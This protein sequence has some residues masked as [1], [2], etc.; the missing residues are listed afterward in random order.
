LF[1]Y[2]CEEVSFGRFPFWN[3]YENLGQPFAGSPT[4]L[5]FYPITILAV[6]ATTLSVDRDYA[7]SFCVGFHVLV[8]V[9]TCY[10]FIHINRLTRA[11]AV[12]GGL[13]YAFSGAVLFQWNNL[14]F[15]IGAAW[16]PEALRQVKIILDGNHYLVG[17]KVMDSYFACTD[18]SYKKRS[19]I[20]LNIIALA[21]VLSMLI[22]GGDPQ[23]AYNVLLCLVIF[24]LLLRKFTFRTIIY[25]LIAGLFTFM[26]S[27][28]QI[29]PATEF[30]QLSDRTLAQH[31]ASIEYFSF[32]LLRIFEFLF[33]GVSGKLFPVNSGLTAAFL[34]E[35]NLWTPSTYIGFLPAIFAF[36]AILSIIVTIIRNIA[37]RGFH[38]IFSLR[39]RYNMILA[40]LV[41]LIFFLFASFGNYFPIY[42]LLQN[43]PVY[44]F[45]RYPSKL[46]TI[47]TL[48]ISFFAAVGFDAF[49]LN[50][51]FARFTVITTRIIVALYAAFIIFILCNDF[52]QFANNPLFGSFDDR[53]AKSNLICSLI[54]VTIIWILLECIYCYIFAGSDKKSFFGFRRIF[55]GWCLIIIL[56]IDLFIANS[57]LVVSL[58]FG[59]NRAKSDILKLIE[60]DNEL[61]FA[62]RQPIRI[63]RVH[64]LRYPQQF[65][66]QSSVNRIEEIINWEKLTLNPR[67]PLAWRVGVVDVRGTMMHKDYYW[68]M[69]QIAAERKNAEKQFADGSFERHLEQLGAQY[70]IAAHDSFAE[71]I[72]FNADRIII[73]P[74]NIGGAE[75][76]FID[77]ISVW[78]LRNPF[79][80]NYILYEPNRIIFDVEVAGECETVVLAEQ[81]WNGWR[82]YVE[83]KEIPVKV[84]RKIFRAV[85][86]PKG[87][88]RV[89]MIYDPPLI[90]IG[91][92]ITLTGILL[93]IIMCL[94]GVKGHKGH[95]GHEGH[96]GRKGQK[97]YV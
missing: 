32:H 92:L 22:L 29:L 9:F 59:S 85:E 28:I 38:A 21:I 74:Q 45:F 35:K 42:R 20:H 2:I 76:N 14:P 43:L 33:A 13:G 86:L 17:N 89:T 48:A 8:A 95:K 61:H 11:A 79:V 26:F 30:L 57:W 93:A 54:I 23:S 31:D 6:L 80:R 94:S 82:A 39:K 63:Y 68:A 41:I 1:W 16:L 4:S 37:R 36:C 84:V 77:N 25:F 69:A 49:G 40:I 53:L 64:S 58:P 97:I 34:N 91:G 90:K 62:T 7:Y 44:N 83:G 70:I 46:L 10:R 78:R 75:S 81:Y 51:R 15:L 47:A 18:F 60:T 56:T 96:K 5:C 72:G 27:A 73:D 19:G 87:K 65:S 52:P 88:H 12:F 55:S 71:N 66:E 24:V 50:E 3:P 67:Y